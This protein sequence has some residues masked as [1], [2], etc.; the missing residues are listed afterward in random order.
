MYGKTTTDCERKVLV[1]EKVSDA[2]FAEM[3]SRF[4]ACLSSYQI[5]FR[6]SSQGE[7]LV[8]TSLKIWGQT[9]Q[10]S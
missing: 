8:S 10:T 4:R 2:E 9:E 7:V 1:D 6:G 5:I 3:K